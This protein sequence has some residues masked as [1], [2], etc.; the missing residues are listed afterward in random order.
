M[1]MS[2]FK[3]AEAWPYEESELEA[4][5]QRQERRN[6]RPKERLQYNNRKIERRHY[7]A[8][9][10]AMM[11]K[12]KEVKAGEEYEELA[13]QVA[14]Q[15]KRSYLVWNGDVTNDNMIVDQIA[16]VSGDERVSPLLRDHP[17]VV[18]FNTLPLDDQTKKKKKKNKK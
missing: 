16:E 6:E 14:R 8:W 12:M 9:L 4:L 17:I 10:E 15:A 18:P 7:G 13:K 5:R 2:N 11:H 1:V 3:L